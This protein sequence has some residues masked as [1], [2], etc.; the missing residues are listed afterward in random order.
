M[1]KRFA[2]ILFCSVGLSAGNYLAA[3]PP[4][5]PPPGG[6]STAAPF[7]T[8]SSILLISAALFGFYK[9]VRRKKT[10]Y[11]TNTTSV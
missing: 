6:I 1:L 8:Q 4:P 5:P 2:L 9:I 3:Q 7:D 11:S 10:G